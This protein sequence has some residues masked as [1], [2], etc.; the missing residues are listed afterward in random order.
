MTVKFRR[1]KHEDDFIKVRDFLISTY[2]KFKRPF[3]WTIERWNF[4]VMA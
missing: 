3:N 4:A 1:Y 2:N